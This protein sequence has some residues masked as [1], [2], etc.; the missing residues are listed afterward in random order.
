MAPSQIHV[1]V[2]VIRDDSGNVLIAQRPAGKSMAGAWEFPGGKLHSGELP[3][4][5][6]ARELREELGIHLKV[7]RHLA[8]YHHD[9]PEQRVYLYVWIVEA[10]DGVPASLEGQALK[11]LQPARLM[12]EGLL[13]AD[14]IIAKLL[15][16]RAAVNEALVEPALR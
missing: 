13:P 15:Q 11:W 7:A 2:G 6:L 8:R 14:L 16:A 5:G 1:A 9:Y 3:L 10:W 12:A 4:H